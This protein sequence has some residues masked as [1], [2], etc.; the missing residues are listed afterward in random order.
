MTNF[1]IEDLLEKVKPYTYLTE[2]RFR[3]LAQICR[4]L[5]TNHIPGDIVECGTYKGGSAAFLSKHM[6]DRHLWLYDSFQ[7]MP[8]TLERDGIEA[9]KWVGDCLASPEDLK[10]VMRL[11]GTDEGTFSIKPGWFHETFQGENLPDTVALLHCD[12]DWYDSVTLVLDTFYDRVVRGGCIV[13]DDFGYWEGCR[14][15]FYDFCHRCGEKPLLE[16]VGTSQAYWVKGQNDNRTNHLIFPDMTLYSIAAAARPETTMSVPSVEKSQA[17]ELQPQMQALQRQLMTITTAYERETQALRSKLDA[18]QKKLKRHRNQLRRLRKRLKAGQRQLSSIQ[19]QVIADSSKRSFRLSHIWP[20]LQGKIGILQTSAKAFTS[21]KTPSSRLS[22]PNT[23][24]LESPPPISPLTQ[25]ADVTEIQVYSATRLIQDWKRIY[26]IDI[27]QEFKGVDTF[28][29]YQ[30]NQS[31]LR[32]FYPFYLFGSEHLYAQLE[33][34]DWYYMPE[35]WE[36]AVAAQDIRPLSSV[37]EIG[38]GYGFF[39]KYCQ[40]FDIQVTGLETN[41]KAVAIAKQNNLSVENFDLEIFSET[42]VERFDVVCSFQVL[43]HVPDPA[44]FLEYAVQTLK[45][46]GLLILCVPNANSFL[47]H[48]YC[49]LDMPPHHMHQWSA[50]TF[51][52]LENLFPLRLEAITYEPLASYHISG[53]VDSYGQYFKRRLPFGQVLFNSK[54]FPFYKKM[55]QNPAIRSCLRGQSLYARFRKI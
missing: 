50:D 40:K 22:S 9:A 17:S 51:K 5:N 44:S 6:G 19:E 24:D 41:S 32:F 13:L 49:L 48:Q 2:E 3:N 11:V 29:L 27:S 4:Y 45:P 35:K 12:A 28:R 23:A 21:A 47:K 31:Q 43:E 10:E 25:Q 37:L 20:K 14:E 42:N 1:S 39:I 38:S 33:K 55:L 54:T 8:Q 15:A 36:Y 52:Y 30:C 7:G 18:K 53:Y 46:G 26:D 34:L 16:R